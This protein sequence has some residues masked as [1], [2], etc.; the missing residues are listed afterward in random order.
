MN[1]SEAKRRPRSGAIPLIKFPNRVWEP[2]ASGIG[3]VSRP[4]TAADINDRMELANALGAA[5]MES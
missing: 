3:W 1:K 5:I 2:A 4:V